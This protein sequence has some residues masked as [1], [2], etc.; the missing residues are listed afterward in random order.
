MEE[1][2]ENSKINLLY[3]DEKTN[4]TFYKITNYEKNIFFGIRISCFDKTQA[5][6]IPIPNKFR[7]DT[8]TVLDM[9][10]ENENI[11]KLYPDINYVYTY[12]NNYLCERKKAYNK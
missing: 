6:I 8:L 9:F 1:S 5:E 4:I 2:F 7:E 3:L 12:Y 10:F 11:A